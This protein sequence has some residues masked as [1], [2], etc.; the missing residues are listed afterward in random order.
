MVHISSLYG[1]C[2]QPNKHGTVMH[3]AD[4]ALGA[5]LGDGISLWLQVTHQVS[6]GHGGRTSC[7][8]IL[9]APADPTSVLLLMGWDRWVHRSWQ[10]MEYGRCVAAGVM[11]FDVLC[12]DGRCFAET[13]TPKAGWFWR[14]GIATGCTTC[15]MFFRHSDKFLLIW[16][17]QLW[18]SHN[19]PAQIFMCLPFHWYC[20]MQ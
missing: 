20:H 5:L 2:I 10:N 6:T 1:H 3:T 9:S 8:Y 12:G 14:K 19:I 18:Q 13:V 4:E 16:T 7:K 15:K 17:S 11:L